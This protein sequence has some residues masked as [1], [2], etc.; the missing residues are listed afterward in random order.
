MDC[1]PELIE[2]MGT[3][4]LALGGFLPCLALI[5]CCVYLLR[6]SSVLESYGSIAI[7]IAFGFSTLIL[8]GL[9]GTPLMPFSA[10]FEMGS[11]A[12]GLYEAFIIAAIPEEMARAI[13]LLGLLAWRRDRLSSRYCLLTGAIVGLVFASVENTFYCM[14]KG[15]STVGE[16]AIT[17]VPLHTF[18]GAIV[19]YA[20]GLA[21]HKR[22]WLWIPIAVAITAVL[23]G[24]NNFSFALL[25]RETP[26]GESTIP[27]TGIGAVLAT[28]WPSNLAAVLIGAG[29][30]FCFA[31]FC[32]FGPS[33]QERN[34]AH[35]GR[36]PQDPR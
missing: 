14:L 22:Q 16:R 7:Y 8:T 31:R 17:S 13:A 32:G 20:V 4:L 5:L 11:I 19:G 28:N 23:H 26:D 27:T 21:I 29:L 33:D 34:E 6:C 2:C 35:L 1:Q 18:H 3:F 25:Y 9:I 10:R 30:T 12:Q 15:W 36:V 24:A